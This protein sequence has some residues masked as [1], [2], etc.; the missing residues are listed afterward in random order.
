MLLGLARTALQMWAAQIV[1]LSAA[2]AAGV[3]IWKALNWVQE[4]ITPTKRIASRVGEQVAAT[5][6]GVDK[7]N[8]DLN[9]RIH[10]TQKVVRLSYALHNQAQKVDAFGE[11]VEKQF[12]ESKQRMPDAEKKQVK[13][14]IDRQKKLYS[15][16]F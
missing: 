14:F 1:A 2:I 9:I 10:G 12:A 5:I 13:L 3:V 8:K 4:R 11:Q 7:V 6:F 16:A 15:L